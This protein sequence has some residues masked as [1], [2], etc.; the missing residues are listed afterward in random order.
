MGES[1]RPTC[2]RTSASPSRPSRERDR[3][4]LRQVA[5]E[6]ERAAHVG[7]RHLGGA[8]DRRGHH[9]RQRALAEVA[10]QQP[11]QEALLV[12]VGAREQRAR[13]PRAAPPA[14]RR[15]PSRRSRPNA[16]VDLGDR[17]R[18]LGGGR[19]RLAQL[20][21]AD[22]DL[23]LGQ[24]PGQER[25]RGR[26]L[27]GRGARQQRRDRL[28]LG[29]A[30]AG[31]RD[32]GG[33]V[34]QLAQA[35][36]M[37]GRVP[38]DGSM[39]SDCRSMPPSQPRDPLRRDRRHPRARDADGQPRRLHADDGSH[40]RDW[41]VRR[42]IACRL[43]FKG[44][45]RAIRQPRRWTE[46]FF[47]D[48]ATAL[49]AGH[50]PCAECRREDYR[51]WQAAWP[52]A[53]HRRRR[54]GPRPA[55][56]PARRPRQA[57]VRGAARRAARTACSWTRGERAWLLAGGAL[58]PWTPGGYG[59]PE[60]AQRGETVTVL[61]PRRRSRDRRGYAACACTRPRCDLSNPSAQP[62]TCVVGGHR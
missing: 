52:G 34:G 31:G 21:P 48:E 41:Q 12:L 49:A 42:W 19:R 3:G 15:R 30:R 56:R 17:Q 25:D 55:R 50:R 37:R 16:R 61:T 23:A 33:D 4:G 1:G 57:H 47:L 7:L 27:V 53:R 22:A 40:R 26:D 6:R 36:R 46:L 43:E 35:H 38:M 59:A 39:R 44:R 58:R 20:R 24:P 2:S 9:A 60:P 5:A 18:R 11:D 45:R 51:R 29:L 8:R 54:D 32:G 62:I 10:E 28:G 13:A 14:S